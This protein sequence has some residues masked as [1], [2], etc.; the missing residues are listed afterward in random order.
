MRADFMQRTILAALSSFIVV[1]YAWAGPDARRD[2]PPNILLIIA[3]DLGWKDV[4][5]HGCAD[6]ETPNID[7]LA[8]GGARLE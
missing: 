5:Y 4:G 1:A 6:I 3:D 2:P 8:A 7:G